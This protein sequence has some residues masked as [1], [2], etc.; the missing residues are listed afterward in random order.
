MEIKVDRIPRKSSS[1][2]LEKNRYFGIV[3][4]FFENLGAMSG[5]TLKEN[6]GPLLLKNREVC[7]S[8]GT[9]IKTSSC[10]EIPRKKIPTGVMIHPN[11]PL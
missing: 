11:L 4:S 1:E 8:H 9:T 6:L 7:S 3:G 5:D 10:K 2:N